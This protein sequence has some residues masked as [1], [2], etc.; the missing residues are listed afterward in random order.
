MECHP[1]L[2]RTYAAHARSTIASSWFKLLSRSDCCVSLHSCSSN[3]ASNQG[4]IQREVPL[5][6]L[7]L[8]LYTASTGLGPESPCHFAQHRKDCL[9][10]ARPLEEPRLPVT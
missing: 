2:P 9:R 1:L 7:S 3:G 8:P 10:V 6:G 5:T 4:T